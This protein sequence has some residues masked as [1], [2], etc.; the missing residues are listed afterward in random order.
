MYDNGAHGDNGPNDG[1]YG[2]FIK[3][4]SERFQ[5]Y[6][7]AE[8]VAAARFF[9][10]GAEYK[11]K[12]LRIQSNLVINE[13][14]A[15]ND[16]SQADQDDQYDDWIELYNNTGNI[17]PLNNYFLSDN[18]ENLF[19]WQFPDTAIGALGY[20]TVWADEDGGQKGL[21]AILNCQERVKSYS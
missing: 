17:I 15:L 19:K 4:K 2:A 20:I 18:A 7:Y 3:P 5:Y 11:L 9:P 16:T 21:H 10:E 8:N 13:F 14:L 12:N 6:I 1:V